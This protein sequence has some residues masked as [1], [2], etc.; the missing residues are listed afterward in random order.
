MPASA[1]PVLTPSTPAGSPDP[2]GPVSVDGK[3]FRAGPAKFFVKG[4]TYG[5]FAPSPEGHHFASPEQTARDFDLIRQL[6]ANLVRV[7]YVPPRWLLDL[8][9]EAQLKVL[10]DIPWP[11]HLCFLDS[12][13]HRAEARRTVREA[14]RAGRDHNALFA[15]SVVNE[16]PP[17]I[18]RWSGA[19]RIENFIDELVAE[20]KAQNPGGLCTFTSFP[21]TEF[22][23][24]ETPDFHTFNVYLHDR[25][26][27][28]AYLARLQILA[29]HRP[30]VLGEFGMDSL[31]E[32]KARQCEF[33]AWQ[34]ESAFRAGLAGTVVFSFTDDWFR[35]GLQIEDWS[36][37]L[38]TRDRSRKDSFPVVRR[39]YLQAPRFPLP[40]TPKVSV[41]V[42]GYNG[43]RTLE[44]CLAS[45]LAL[46]YPDYEIILVDD[47]STDTTPEIAGRFPTVRYL[48]Q[49]NQ[50][51]SAARNAGIAAA[52][53]E[54]IAFTDSDCRADPDWLYYLVQD[55]LNGDWV[56]LGGHNFLPPEDSLVAAAVMASPG[57]PAH[58]M[59]TDLEAEHVPGCNMAFYKWAL[60]A[61][62][63]FDPVFRKAGDDVDLCWRLQQA[64]HK[65]GFS[66]AGFV[67]HYR[68]S[69]VRAY[70]RQQAGYGE[71]EALLARKHPEYFNF[72]G[73]GIWRGKIYA[74][75]RNG[76]VLAR[77]VIY[78]GIFGSG[79]FQ[80]LYTTDPALALMLGT[81][82]GYHGCVNLPL[83]VA[84]VYLS[85]L[86]PLALASLGL[87]LG[88]CL[89][90]AA[91]AP[92]PKNHRRVWSRP[93]VA[94]LFFLQPVVRGWARL[95]VRLNLRTVG[96]FTPI[97]PPFVSSLPSS[98]PVI[99]IAYWTREGPDRLGLLRSFI[100][101]LRTKAWL[102]RLD[103][104]WG[105]YDLEIVAGKWSRLR[106]T[107]VTEELEQGKRV[108]RCR[109][110]SAW[111]AQAWMVSLAALAGVA[112]LTFLFAASFPWV[113][114][115]ILVLPLVLW[116]L[117]DESAG[118]Q[119]AATQLLDETAAR[120]HCVKL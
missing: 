100:E 45:L 73:G 5:P 14:A 38:T 12:A 11:K 27:F 114:T 74:S 1:Q 109:L 53:G 32:G 20:A 61:V 118:W 112:L 22:L 57:G 47:G 10:V 58:V 18:V 67:W 70:L 82:L 21:P 30:L 79:F 113:W 104:G 44:A 66:H 85:W 26:A 89:L 4:V 50:G 80:R 71:A 62:G 29:A 90:A 77:D 52:T 102:V 115:S 69:T 99:S 63:G 110:E 119:N 65:I 72:S 54:I 55:L 16:I 105:D 46:N 15:C 64:G 78:H 33:L 36:F 68:R 59:L 107:S 106:L 31:R 101:Q 120:C 111:S 17:E 49:T 86:W 3:F 28:E 41:V 98:R 88:I 34:I 23:Q 9:A 84:S 56:G 75:G 96:P 83:L 35:G 6:G 97:R 108:F 91:Q 37:G 81:S 93:L 25:K 94:L 95:A 51:L 19:G 103:T 60:Q 40:R 87:S 24:P 13:K 2:S 42:A 48:A 8:A 92:L 7:Y 43:A 76:V 39:Q 117:D 116:F